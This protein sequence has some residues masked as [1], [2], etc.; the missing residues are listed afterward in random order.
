VIV[1]VIKF[2]RQNLGLCGQKRIRD[3]NFE[4][5]VDLGK[6]RA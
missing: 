5:G 4:I 3:R 1:E 6:E 2:V